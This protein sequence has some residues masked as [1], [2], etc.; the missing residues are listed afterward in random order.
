MLQTVHGPVLPTERT[1][2]VALTQVSLLGVE[3]S[4]AGVQKT[5]THAEQ[6]VAFGKFVLG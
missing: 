5:G 4:L 1:G 6:G 2:M 3:G